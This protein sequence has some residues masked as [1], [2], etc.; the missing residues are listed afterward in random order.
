MP[1]HYKIWIKSLLIG[2]WAIFVLWH[3][4]VH[5]PIINLLESAL[6]GAM[7]FILLLGF[8]ALGKRVFRYTKISFAT[9]IEECCF[10]FGLGTGV[11]IVLVIG[12]AALG[13]LYKILTSIDE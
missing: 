11:T 2:G 12:L 3:F 6:N 1:K 5:F 7:L 10:S 4:H 9:F 8:T 13:L